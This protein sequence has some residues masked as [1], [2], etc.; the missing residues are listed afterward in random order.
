MQVRNLWKAKTMAAGLAAALAVGACATVDDS[1]SWT[2]VK[3]AG[4]LR[5]LFSDKTF[6]GKGSY[7]LPTA[8]VSYNRADGQGL[9]VI[10]AQKY[11][12][13]WAVAGDDQICTESERGK[14]CY[15][16]QRHASNAKFHRSFNLKT[17]QY[18][19]FTVDE[20]IAQF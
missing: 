16:Y 3:G 1:K 15:R 20:G 11:R 19:E 12:Y 17:G 4:E 5:K 14:N 8:W 7:D 18:R 2:D 9:F 13:T 6:S 10:S